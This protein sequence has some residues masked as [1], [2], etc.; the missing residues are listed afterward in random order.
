[1]GFAQI[2][3][4]VVETGGRF[5]MGGLSAF[6]EMDSSNVNPY[7]QQVAMDETPTSEEINSEQLLISAGHM[8]KAS[9]LQ[10]YMQYIFMRRAIQMP[11]LVN[12]QPTEVKLTLNM[13]FYYGKESGWKD[14]GDSKV[15]MIGPNDH[16]YCHLIPSDFPGFD[17]LAEH[18]FFN[19]NSI[20]VKSSQDTGLHTSTFVGFLPYSENTSK[21]NNDQLK[22]LLNH[23]TANA[24]RNI[25]FTIRA[26][27]G[28]NYFFEFDDKEKN[29]TSLSKDT[30]SM[31][32]DLVFVPEVLKENLKE[33]QVL[34]FGTLVFVKNNFGESDVACT[35]IIE[36]NF[37]AFDMF[38]QLPNKS[39]DGSGS[40]AGS[41]RGRHGYTYIN[42][43]VT[44]KIKKAKL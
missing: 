1:M 18:D 34:S 44:Q 23:S 17:R 13:T 10:N 12:L 25:D 43:P 14:V 26:A 8:T 7:A 33:K 32:P 5:I 24:E 31:N 35:F 4:K 19:F 16:A 29:Y 22:T 21:Y 6:M 2:L 41:S 15:R 30:I 39:D 11:F 9:I 20:N 40:G 37:T 28:N 3:A 36:M 27:S 38:S 42:K